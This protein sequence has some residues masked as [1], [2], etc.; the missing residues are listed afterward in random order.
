MLHTPHDIRFHL[1]ALFFIS[2]YSGSKCYSPPLDNTGIR[3]LPCNF[4]NSSLLTV[5]CKT[6]PFASCVSAA[7]RV[8][9]DVHIFVESIT[10]VKHILHH[11]VT[12]CEQLIKFFFLRFKVF[13]PLL[14]L[15]FCILSVAIFVAFFPF[16]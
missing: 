6:S 14:S 4:R 2:V 5:T 10:Q 3:V 8:C 9:K 1:D 15:Y 16:V 7:N 13:V 11:F 12:F